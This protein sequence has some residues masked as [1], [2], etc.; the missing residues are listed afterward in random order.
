[1]HTAAPRAKQWTDQSLR[2][3]APLLV[4]RQPAL[5]RLARTAAPEVGRHGQPPASLMPESTQFTT[6]RH[7]CRARACRG[8]PWPRGGQFWS[9][10]V[11]R[12]AE[13]SGSSDARTVRELDCP[14]LPI[15]QPLHDR[16]KQAGPEADELARPH[17]PLAAALAVRGGCRGSFGGVCRLRHCVVD[18]TEPSH[19][20]ELRAWSS[21]G[22]PCTL[23]R[24]RSVFKKNIM[25]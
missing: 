8:L 6:A 11:Y 3:S 15:G 23:E 10:E 19:H 16:P 5:G 18:Q 9:S 21:G 12:K 25:G 13:E 2:R 17:A 24:V 1:M 14:A 22:G 4:Q 20:S 7:W